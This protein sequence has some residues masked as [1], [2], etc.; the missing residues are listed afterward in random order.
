MVGLVERNRISISQL[1][2]TDVALLKFMPKYYIQQ[3]LGISNFG[4]SNFQFYQTTVNGPATINAN[5]LGYIE[6][7]PPVP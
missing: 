2:S 6:S 5:K 4:I 1:I 7:L 3:N